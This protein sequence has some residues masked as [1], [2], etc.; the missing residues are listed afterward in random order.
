MGPLDIDPYRF[1]DS[2]GHFVLPDKYG[3]LSGAGHDAVITALCE[4]IEQLEARVEELE[5]W[6]PVPPDEEEF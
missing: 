4:I 6:L 3:H 2:A 5:Q 1:L